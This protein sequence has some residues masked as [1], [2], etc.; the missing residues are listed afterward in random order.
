M[1]L[2]TDVAVRHN[3]QPTKQGLDPIDDQIEVEAGKAGG[4]PLLLV[5]GQDIVDYFS[6]LA[7]S[8]DYD[9]CSHFGAVSV[10]YGMAKQLS[11]ATS[12]IASKSSCFV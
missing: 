7:V 11:L 1:Q 12:G 5:C 9:D 6:K 4:L 8:S 2:T 10:N 3:H